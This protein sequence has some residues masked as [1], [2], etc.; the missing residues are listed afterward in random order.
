MNHREK[1]GQ[2]LKSLRK[3]AG[4]SQTEMAEKTGLKRQNLDRV[5]SGQFNTGID[6]IQKMCE[7]LGVEINI[8]KN[9]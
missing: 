4:I 8:D 1:I 7:V 5:E 3:E 2:K 9:I 6:T